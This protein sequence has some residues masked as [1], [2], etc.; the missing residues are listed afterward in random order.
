MFNIRFI[1]LK[2]KL[3]ILEDGRLPYYKTSALRGG[4]GQMLLDQN[5]IKD[6]KCNQCSFSENCIVQN[7]MYAKFKIKPPYV[8]NKESMGYVADCTD[9]STRARKGNILCFSLTLFGNTACY[10]TSLIYA[11]TALGANGIGKDAI[12]FRIKSITDRKNN[13]ILDNNNIYIGNLGIETLE[14]YINERMEQTDLSCISRRVILITPCT[15]KSHGNFLDKFDGFSLVTSI[16]HKIKMYNLYEGNDNINYKWEEDMFPEI[17]MQNIKECVIPRYST[18]H[19]SKIN[20]NGVKG[21][22][23]LDKC[24]PGLLKILYAAEILH[25]GKNTRF[26]F[27]KILVV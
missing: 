11:L 17:S 5:C 7:I 18:V 1:E 20:L 9:Y 14:Q 15:I 8:T 16:L 12:H 10:I 22:L 19:N 24:T 25:I 4:T 2:I 6:R 23:F 27:G 26:G 13:I 3:E 21:E